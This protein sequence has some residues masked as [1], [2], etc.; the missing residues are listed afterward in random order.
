LQVAK[1][2]GQEQGKLL[3]NNWI[4]WH[5]NLSRTQELGDATNN[6]TSQHTRRES[7][8]KISTP[9]CGCARSYVSNNR[10]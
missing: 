6:A 9:R 4:L 5:D 1:K 8:W 10:I 2:H 3:T 7:I